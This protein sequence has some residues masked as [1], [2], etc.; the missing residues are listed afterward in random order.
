MATRLSKSRILA[1]SQCLKR[2]WL[3]VKQPDLLVVTPADA[4]RFA[5]G[6]RVGEIARTLHPGGRLIGHD[7]N[8]S[9][10]LIETQQHI[11]AGERLLFE[12][13]FE[14]EGILIRADIFCNDNA[15]CQFI[16]IKSST[17]VKDYHLLD[18]AVQNW[19]LE[20]AGYSVTSSAIAY[21]NN[22]FVYAGDGNYQGLLVVEDVTSYLDVLKA[23]CYPP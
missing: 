20:G 3:Q 4:R 15:G 22:E 8:R 9:L 13:T 5:M 1:G 6:R 7:D 19:V 17:A 11:D 23:G 12:A 18:C 2:L 21:I 16:E 14:R 10:A